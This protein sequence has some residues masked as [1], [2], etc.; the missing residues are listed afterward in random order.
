M[1]KNILDYFQETADRYPDKTALMFQDQ[2]M[3]FKTLRQRSR[4]LAAEIIEQAGQAR[5]QPVA[6]LLP[7]CME[8]VI[9]DIGITYSGNIFM[10]LDVKTPKARLANIIKQIKPVLVITNQAC[11]ALLDGVAEEPKRILVGEEEKKDYP[12]KEEALLERRRLQIDTD[13]FCIINTSGSTGTPKGVVLNHKSFID[14]MEWSLE[15]FPFDGS[16]IIGALSPVVFDIYDFE[17]C[18]MMAKGAS[19]ALLDSS[20]GIFP[21]RLLEELNQKKVNFLFWVP[22]ILVNIANMDLLSRIPL[23]HLKMVWFAGEVF[24]T[25][26]F[27]YWKRMLPQAT[28]VNLYGPIEIT[29]DCI[30]YIVDREFQDEE[31]LPIGFPCKNTDILLLNENGELCGPGEAGEICV[32]GTSLAM[33]YYNNAQKTEAAFVQNPL[34]SSYPE[35]I[36]RTGD[37][38]RINERGE[39]CFQGRK[40][41]LVK[42]QGYRIELGEIEHAA[43]NA[44][45]L[46]RNGCAVYDYEK[47][48][49][50]LF[51]E[52][53]EL[54]EVE[55]R[56]GLGEVFPRYMIP[57]VYK[58]VDQ[59]PQNQ[60]GKIDRLLL[61]KQV[62]Q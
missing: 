41:S 4:Q 12:G 61:S 54:T 17:I 16:E 26:Q 3:D 10:N 20:L 15:T 9:S 31:P 55:I 28:F 46:V 13:P 35:L 58:P 24:P 59:L 39:I 33:G 25:K 38:G 6:V 8:T 18:L 56:K 2:T 11:A 57:T 43:V 21:A 34:N 27:N 48:Q 23:P 5:N 47:K 60:N 50:V 1:K 22:T 62:N 53:G 14:F 7:K 29:L 37:I 51:Y 49:I 52:P 44:L 36:Y 40:D 19:I 30:Y 32:R 45:E 42:H